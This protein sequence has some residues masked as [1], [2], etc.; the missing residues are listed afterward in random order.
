MKSLSLSKSILITPFK[1]HFGQVN[2]HLGIQARISIFG[3]INTMIYARPASTTSANNPSE[4]PKVEPPNYIPLHL[5]HPTPI[6]SEFHRLERGQIQKTD[7]NK[8]NRVSSFELER[9]DVGL[10]VHKSPVNLGDWIALL[11]VKGLRI[12]ADIFFQGKYLHRA[13]TLETV[14]AVP[15]MVAGALR[16]LTSL[17]QMRHDGGWIS[18]LLHE[19]ENERMH[20]MIWM[21]ATKPTLLERM[22]V[23]MVQG[24]FYNFYFVLYALFPRIAHRTVGYL[25][26]E[27]VISYTQM[28]HQIDTGV[29]KNSPAPVIAIE[30]YGLTTD[31]TIR[32]VVLAIRA[33]E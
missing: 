21:K 18:I 20:L 19:A 5:M 24:V 31:A 14:A 25:E 6:R 32:D 22:V 2:S 30:Y 9:L 7:T 3:G 11:V 15:G 29:I 12:P 16:H 8:E 23:T 17:R 27:A 33:D 26:E 13:V 28:L 4:L 1:S 10:N